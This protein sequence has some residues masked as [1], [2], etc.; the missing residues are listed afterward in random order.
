MA[1]SIADDEAQVSSEQDVDA[2]ALQAENASLRDRVLR[3]LA[4]AEN[5]RRR[6]ERTGQE[7]RQYAIS[8]FAR[9]LL[10]VADNLQRTIAAAQHRAPGKEQAA[11]LEGV[12]ATERMLM[13][14]F[15]RF[16][17][18]KIRALGKPFDPTLDEAI[19]ELE[20]TSHPP[21]TVV[22]VA[23]DGYTIHGRLLRPARVVVAKHR[24]AAPPRSDTQATQQATDLESQSHSSES[25]ERFSSVS[26]ATAQAIRR[27][28]RWPLI[29]M[30]S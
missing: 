27:R 8:G 14:G 20:D 15:E 12:R 23:E 17:I 11:L 5:T 28:A 18:R 24:A 25:A 6:A 3:A 30:R 16:G 19:M 26:R 22:R 10:P 9:E 1:D 7:A 13:H 4:D 2:A 29:L 21:G